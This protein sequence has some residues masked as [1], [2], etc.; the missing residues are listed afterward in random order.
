VYLIIGD[1]ALIP[2]SIDSRTSNLTAK[3]LAMGSFFAHDARV[4]RQLVGVCEA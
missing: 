3:I 2:F 1:R 4:Y